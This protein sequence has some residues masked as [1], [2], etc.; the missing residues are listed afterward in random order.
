MKSSF[1]LL[2]RFLS[3]RQHTS[4]HQDSTDGAKLQD[5]EA[6][7]TVSPLVA[8]A[9]EAAFFTT[10]TDLRER[11]LS[12]MRTFNEQ[13]IARVDFEDGDGLQEAEFRMFLMVAVRDAVTEDLRG[14]D[15]ATEQECAR[16]C[17]FIENAVNNLFPDS[18]E[19][20]TDNAS[21]RA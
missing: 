8:I 3:H 12:A 19:D 7:P 4:V 2:S 11:L 20:D 21:P 9:L 16:L 18:A 15:D 17:R 1:P 13:R 10:D 6:T 5:R 14:L